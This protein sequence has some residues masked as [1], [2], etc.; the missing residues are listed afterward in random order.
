MLPQKELC[1]E[2][3]Q[4]LSVYQLHDI[5]LS[6]HFAPS[7]FMSFK[8][9]NRPLSPLSLFAAAEAASFQVQTKDVLVIVVDVLTLCDYA[10][11]H[12]TLRSLVLL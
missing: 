4:S 3:G 9:L 7:R 2:L 1:H 12:G 11:N 8:P 10:F 5:N 6:H